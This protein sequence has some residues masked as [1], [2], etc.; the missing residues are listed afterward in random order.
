MTRP[1]DILALAG[2]A[3]AAVAAWLYVALVHSQGNDPAGWVV[4]VLVVGASG[5][6]YASYRP[7]PARLQVLGASAVLLGVL[8]L[9]AI[10][11]IG[12][13]VMLAAGLCL[14]SLLRSLTAGPR[15]TAS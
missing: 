5:A 14:V 12:L 1:I 3:T 2:A 11:S 9:A 15:P 13:L 10:L 6:A 7:A 8:G 4:L